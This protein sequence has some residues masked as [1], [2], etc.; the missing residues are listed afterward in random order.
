LFFL[1]TLSLLPCAGFGQSAPLVPSEW[2][3]LLHYQKS[4]TGAWINDAGPQFFITEA[5]SQNPQA[6]LEASI[7]ELKRAGSDFHCKFPARA[8]LLYRRDRTLPIRTGSCP[9]WEGFRNRLNAT[10]ASLVFSSYYLNNPASA[11]GH[12]FLRVHRGRRAGEAQKPAE[13]LDTGIGYA[14]TVTT[15]NAIAYAFYGIFGLFRGDYT[16]LPYYY[17]VR[18]YADAE[19]RDLWSYELALSHSELELLV[20]HLWELDRAERRYYYFSKNCSYEILAILEAI[21][22]PER[23]E[24]GLLA[25]LPWFVI[26]SHTLQSLT[27]EPGLVRS[28][29]YRPSLRKQLEARLSLLAPEQ[30]KQAKNWKEIASAPELGARVLDARLDW[31]DFDHFEDLVREKPEVSALKQQ[32]LAARAQ[33]GVVL[34]EVLLPSDVGPDPSQ[35]HPPR[36]VQLSLG[37]VTSG[38]SFAELAFRPALQDL[39]DPVAGYPDSAR[40]EFTEAALR[41]SDRVRLQ[42]FSLFRAQS[43]TPISV[44]R[45]DPSWKVGVLHELPQGTRIEASGG[46]TLPVFG[47]RVFGLAGGRLGGGTLSSIRPAATLELGLHYRLGDR[48]ALL[49]S[50][51]GLTSA[52]GW[53][54]ELQVSARL[55]LTRRV[56]IGAELRNGLAWQAQSFFYF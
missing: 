54:E 41:V 33:T 50:W 51:L 40:L 3:R 56:S 29:D 34:Q 46:L 48:W 18:E 53:S 8:I 22:D 42:R 14:A 10:G 39:L 44:V 20:A 15:S 49:A 16:A 21:L 19:N 35:G 11:F 31:I 28:I 24:S 23:P 26:P 30:K 4:L 13:L 32:A 37:K 5:G 25:R 55:H 9:E 36:R 6:E 12:S 38:S 7:A 52:P 1:F 47:A 45:M 2:L 27:Q 17:K 43:L